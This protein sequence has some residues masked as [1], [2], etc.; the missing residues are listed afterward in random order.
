MRKEFAKRILLLRKMLKLTQAELAQ[1]TGTTQ[2]Y[3]SRLEKAERPLSE[4]F[5]L[6]LHK[7]LKVNIHWLLT[8]QGEMFLEE[9][10]GFELVPH[11]GEIGASPGGYFDI[12]KGEIKGY[13]AFEKK[14]LRRFWKPFLVS[15]V[16][17]SMIP[18]LHPGDLVLVDRNPEKLKKLNPGKIYIVNVSYTP[19]YFYLA[20]KYVQFDQ[21]SRKLYCISANPKYAPH[22]IQLAEDEPITKYVIGEAVWVGRELDITRIP[23]QIQIPQAK[24]KRKI[25]KK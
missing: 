6:N 14:F 12:E 11:I 24:K 18:V 4:K 7:K 13:K 3:I 20:A 22:E 9:K 8:G 21:E 15:I 17:D 16:G 19:E 5:L 2:T 25:D 10:E 1:K 23:E